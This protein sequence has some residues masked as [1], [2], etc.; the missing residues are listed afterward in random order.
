M[1]SF[2]VIVSPSYGGAERRFFDIFTALRRDGVDVSMIAPSSLVDTLIADHPDR[3]DIVASL[4]AVELPTWSRLAFIGKFRKLLRT[5][6]R[7]SSFHY[8]LN[9]LWPL[10]L[11]RG[12]TVSM[13]VADCTSVPGP[14][15]GRRTST[16]A[17]LSFFF[18][19][20]IDVLSPSIF[21]SMRGFRSAPKMSLTP[22]G[23]FVVTRPWSPVAKSPTVVFL[24]RLVPGKGIDD[25]LDVV[26]DAWRLLR[27]RVPEGFKFQIA[28]YGPLQNH[29]V[30]RVDLLARAGTPIA[31]V[32][33]AAADALLPACAVVLSMQEVTN[34][35]SRV[36]AEAL[37]AG[38][39]VI[40]RDTGDSREFG[41]D[42][43][44]LVY[45]R[46][47]LDAEEI[48][49]H[50]ATLVGRVV[51]VPAFAQ[52][53]SRAARARFGGTRYVQYFRGIVAEGQPLHP[54]GTRSP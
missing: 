11:G 13:S 29:V 40:V 36:V 41:S 14:L 24:G 16:W 8:P 43:P 2:I 44:G 9:C 20:R 5:L 54:C 38:C 53:L 30:E 35:P 34:Y 52:E 31:F 28:G 33:Y 26:A 18:A 32:G 45:C 10:H 49:D 15:A 17:W 50:L 1:P 4:V 3:A 39:A 46:P 7:G 21:A 27:G 51:S 22:G 48:A 6:P 37:M 23:T 19:A 12:D 25:F 42:L 47:R